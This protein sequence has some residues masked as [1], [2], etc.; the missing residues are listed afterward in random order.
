MDQAVMQAA[1]GHEIGEFGFPAVGPV[2]DV[3]CIDVTLMRATRE[4]TTAVTGVERPTNRGGNGAGLA[5]HIEGLAVFVLKHSEQTR[6]AGEAAH[7]LG[8]DGR[9]VLDLAASGGIVTQGFGID[10]HHDLVVIGGI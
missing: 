9:S 1:Q 6:V 10:V 8:G 7:C 3:V 2:L 4:S 5:S